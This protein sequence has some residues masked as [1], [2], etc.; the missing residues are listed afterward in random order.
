MTQDRDPIDA[1][2]NSPAYILAEDDTDL[3]KRDELRATRLVLEYQK[4]E[5][6][7]QEENIVSTIAAFGGSRIIPKDLAEERLESARETLAADPENVDKQLAVRVAEN[8][9]KL[10]KYYD[11]AR[12]LGRLVSTTCQIEGKCEYVIVTG[13]GP[14]IME[15]ANRGAHDVGAKS[16][17]LNITLPHE[18]APNPYITPELCFQFRYFAIRKMHFLLRAKALV[19]FPGGFGTMDELFEALTLVQT[20]KSLRIPIILFGREFWTTLINW[21]QFV[22]MGV[23]APD[24]LQLM[25]FAEAAE[26]AWQIITDFYADADNEKSS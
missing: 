2:L 11:H 23:I 21:P 7:Q 25:H 9:L 26:Q 16:V 22:E 19:A 1:I 15:A 8:L 24:D 4:T 5:F 6:L 14:G 12:D 18:Q 3:L 10:S 13:G 17:G 20:G